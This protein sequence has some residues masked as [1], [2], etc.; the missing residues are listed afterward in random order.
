MDEEKGIT[1]TSC[2][3]VGLDFNDGFI[4]FSETDYFGNLIDLKHFPLRYHGTGNKADSEMQEVVAKI[5]RFAKEREKPIA[6]EN[7]NFKKAK[8]GTVKA[9][10]KTGKQYNKMVHALDYSRYT[11]RLENAG[12]RENVG[13]I[14][15]NPAYTS[16]IGIEKFSGRM[17]LNRH[18]AASFVIA[19][20]GQGFQ[21]KLQ[22]RLRKVG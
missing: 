11:K 4:S 13:I 6:I 5:V 10:G 20:R 19:R 2:G 3:V 22:K 15:V 9:R 18:Q 21:D 7:L 14:L 8:A 17:K 16:Q 12:F 1:D